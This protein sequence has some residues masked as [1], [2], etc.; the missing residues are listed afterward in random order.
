MFFVLLFWTKDDSQAEVTSLSNPQNCNP[1]IKNIHRWFLSLPVKALPLWS[2][3]L[4]SR[5][6]S[7]D[8]EETGLFQASLASLQNEG[9]RYKLWQLPFNP[10]SGRCL[11]RSKYFMHLPQSTRHPRVPILLLTVLARAKTT[12]FEKAPHSLQEEPTEEPT[13][14]WGKS[15]VWR[16][17]RPSPCKA[18][19][20]VL[21]NS[22]AISLFTS[23]HNVP[24][25]EKT[26][27]E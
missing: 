11:R 15:L 2:W 3:Q 17:R 18:A 19:A 12:A 21:L 24:L 6:P 9:L 13:H 22:S 8:Q 16:A 10:G 14:A 25:K 23:L 1:T 20:A 7:T 27:E 4:L 5:Q 26:C